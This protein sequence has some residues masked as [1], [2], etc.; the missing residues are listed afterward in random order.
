[1]GWKFPYLQWTGAKS[2]EIAL[3]AVGAG[4]FFI[5]LALVWVWVAEQNNP[6]RATLPWAILLLV[7]GAV[8]GVA[9]GLWYSRARSE[10]DRALLSKV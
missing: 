5:V 6:L 4:G 9:G 2:R 3:L 1:M 7:G 10:A 8:L